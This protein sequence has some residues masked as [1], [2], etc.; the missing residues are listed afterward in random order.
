MLV[1]VLLLEHIRYSKKNYTYQ[2]P[3]FH[4]F[5]LC[6]S[7]PIPHPLC[8][9]QQI[10]VPLH[11][12]HNP[13]VCRRKAYSQK[14][15]ISSKNYSSAFSL[16]LRSSSPIP[17]PPYHIFPFFFIPLII[18][19]LAIIRSIIRTKL[20]IQKSIP[21]LY[22]HISLPILLTPL[23][24][25][26]LRPIKK[27]HTALYSETY[28]SLFLSAF[29]LLL[30]ITLSPFLPI[31]PYHPCACRRKASSRYRARCTTTRL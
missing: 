23:Y 26:T 29:L 18:I 3:F 9:Y 1:D 2:N 19:A 10:S 4:P 6:F 27:S 20:A 25:Q 11:S 5:N 31:P 24:S 12:L 17:R 16:Y 8:L 14:T 30:F 28:S 21:L 15:V 13:C 7:S 22:H